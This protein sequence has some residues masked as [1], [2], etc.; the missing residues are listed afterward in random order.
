MCGAP[1]KATISDSRVLLRGFA[2]QPD[3]CTQPRACFVEYQHN[4]PLL[5]V[6]V[7]ILEYYSA[8]GG[9][10][11]AK[12]TTM[13]NLVDQSLFCYPMERVLQACADRFP[14]VKA[15]FDAAARHR[16]PVFTR[17]EFYID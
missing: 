4:D 10:P 12:A 14:D 9:L 11:T 6:L 16:Q 13:L 1:E 7:G 5:G 2:A 3:S 8:S 15:V 17:R